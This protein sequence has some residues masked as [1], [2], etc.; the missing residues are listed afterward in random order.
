MN[1]ADEK[2]S[3]KYCYSNPLNPFLCIFI[4]LKC[5]AALHEET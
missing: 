2:N 1:Q 4:A 5:F 3:P